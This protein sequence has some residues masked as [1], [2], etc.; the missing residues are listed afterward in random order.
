MQTIQHGQQYSHRAR[1]LSRERTSPQK[2]RNPILAAF[3]QNNDEKLSGKKHFYERLAQPTEIRREQVFTHKD[4]AQYLS[5]SKSSHTLSF[6]AG[7][8]I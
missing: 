4:P 2:H 8:R 6:I 3:D 7:T 1:S 5:Q